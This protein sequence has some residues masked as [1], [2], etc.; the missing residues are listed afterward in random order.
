MSVCV[1]ILGS[2]GLVRYG[3]SLILLFFCSGGEGE[4]VKDFD[5][6]RGEAVLNFIGCIFVYALLGSMGQVRCGVSLV[7][8]IPFD[9]ARRTVSYQG[10]S[11]Y[12]FLTDVSRKRGQSRAK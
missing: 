5:G 4:S 10:H 2:T 3:V 9:E 7:V 1:R 11:T 6:Y 12:R 8:F